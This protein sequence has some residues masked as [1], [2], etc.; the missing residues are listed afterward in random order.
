[1]KKIVEQ[2]RRRLAGG[3]TGN[4]IQWKAPEIA[5]AISQKWAELCKRDYYQNLKDGQIGLDSVG[6]VEYADLTPEKDEY[7]R[8]FLELEA[9]PISFGSRWQH[10]INHIGPMGDFEKSY[11]LIT[12]TAQPMWG[13]AL[14]NVNAGQQRAY[15]IGERKL[16]FPDMKSPCKLLVRIFTTEPTDDASIPDDMAAEIASYVVGFYQNPVRDEENN[17]EVKVTNQTQMA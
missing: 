15:K 14:H 7:G 17:L 2:V 1:M 3:N 12:A 9:K 5:L 10:G 6:L 8:W 4:D 11:K 13:N 16:I